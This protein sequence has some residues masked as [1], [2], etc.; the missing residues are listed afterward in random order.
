MGSEMCIR[1]RSSPLGVV[2]GV[3]PWNF[4]FW[5]VIRFAIPTIVAGNSVVLK[6]ASNVPGC[7][8]AL[9][10]LFEKS[11]FPQGVFQ[12]LLIGSKEVAPV[13]SDVRIAAVSLTGSEAAGKAVARE[14]GSHIKK[15]VLEL[16][17]IDPF[18]VLEDAD[19]EVAA[20]TALTARYQNCVQS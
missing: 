2:L 14:A 18:I 17:G 4:P 6:H 13:I 20:A 10:E 19:L 12:T 11:G 9:Q 3:M 7:A 16:G 5:Q 8:L 1:D 15:C